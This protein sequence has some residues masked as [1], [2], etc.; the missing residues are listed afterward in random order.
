MPE[1]LLEFLSEEIPARMQERAAEDLRALVTDALVEQGLLYAEARAHVTPRRLVLVIDGLAAATRETVEER[2]GPRIDAPQPAIDGFLKSAGVAL[3]DCTVVDDKKGKFYLARIR[4]KARA[5]P[6]VVAAAV[7]DIVRRFPWPKSMRWGSG[8]LRWVRPL[9]SVLCTLDGELVDFSVDGLRSGNRTRGHR[10]MAPAEFAVRGY[11]DYAASLERAF[12]MLD[13]SERAEVIRSESRNLAFAQGLDVVED[14][15][16]LRE[17]AGL[18]EWPVVLMGTFAERFLALPPEVVVVVLRSHQKCFALRRAGT[19]KLANRYL[20]T[21][22]IVTADGGRAVVSG[23]DR[24]IAARLA[25][26]GF[27]FEHDRRQPLESL[28][29]KLDR[30]TFHARLGTQGERAARLAGLS[31]RVATAIGADVAK[32]ELAGRLAKADLVSGMVGEFPELQGV[33]GRYYALGER[34]PDEV[35]DAL[36]DHYRPQGP[37][38]AVPGHSVSQAAALADKLD[39]LVGF[40]LIDEKPTGSKDPFALRRAALG[41]IRIVL[42]RQLKLELFPL[43]DE[44]I[45]TYGTYASKADAAVLRRSLLEFLA[46][47]LKVYLRDK[48][49][50]HDLIDAVFAAGRQD[51]LLAV[52]RRVEALDRFL[53]TELGSNLLAGVRRATNIVRIEEK[54]DKRSFDGAPEPGRF[55][56]VEER[57]LAA[58]IAAAEGQ[59]AKALSGEDFEAAMGAVAGLRLPVDAFFDKV[60]V[61]ADDPGLR[62]NRLR[63]LNR[64]RDTVLAVADFSKIEG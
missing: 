4:K 61:N 28:L 59:A 1:L 5:A 29:P 34:L 46:E 12:V 23:N 47:R 31:R 54:K 58:A 63:L 3:A 44:S 49:A 35:A 21:A 26:A 27:F 6:D 55:V 2:K 22:N 52:V 53:A 25:D 38:D 11:E 33:M 18:V 9:H 8:Q 30:V 17:A 24:V 50:R 62:E 42:E 16:L 39:L 48:G 57:T 20:L 19:D 37:G 40:W 32:A 13:S 15:A 36:R 43:I 60:T 41:I 10:F 7:P 45:A 14:E 56:A 51:D 64:I